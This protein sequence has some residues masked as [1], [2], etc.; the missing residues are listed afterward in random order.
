MKFVKRDLLEK[1][2][3]GTIYALQGVMEEYLNIVSLQKWLGFLVW[4]DAVDVLLLGAVFYRVMLWIQGT[5][6]MQI[7]V[8]F[9]LAFILYFVSIYL[10]LSAT[11]LLLDNLANSLT[12]ALIILFQSE[13]RD[14]LARFGVLPFLIGKPQRRQEE[15]L[16][17]VIQSAVYLAEKRIGA[18]IAFEKEM[19]LRNFMERGQFLDAQINKSLL[20]SIFQTQS[21]LHDGALI[22]D[23]AGRIASA[24]C[25]LPLSISELAPQFGTRHRAA[26]GLSETTDSVVIVVSEERG[27]L[28]V[29]YR[30]EIYSREQLTDMRQILKQFLSSKSTSDLEDSHAI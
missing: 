25:V 27:E 20:I 22:I 23:S 18:L 11:Q 14:G 9:L 12:L 3:F 30:G 1:I 29:C 24:G 6:T 21:P 28:S 2:Y 5:R 7:F 19:G 17:V 4:Q 8:G 15:N 26:L 10:E 13:I 16:E